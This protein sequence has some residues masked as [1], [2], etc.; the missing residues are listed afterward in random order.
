[1][2]TSI[3]RIEY[4][5]TLVEDKSGVAYGLLELLKKKGVN[6]VAFTAFP[7]GPGHIQVDFFPDNTKQLQAAMAEAGI[8]LTGPGQA[9]LIQGGDDAGA[10]LKHHQQLSD[11][12]INV[13]AS[14]G[15]SDGTGRFGYVLWVKDEDYERAAS[16]MGV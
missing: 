7:S 6:L 10:I 11:A 13:I 12:G 9:F 1:M 5:H 4:F 14:N 2:T 8:R 15:V 3:R 16:A